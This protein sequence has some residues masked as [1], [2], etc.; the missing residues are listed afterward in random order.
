MAE[1][2]KVEG[3]SWSAGLRL[4]LVSGGP[5]LTVSCPLQVQMMGS[6]HIETSIKVTEVLLPQN[7]FPHILP[8][9]KQDNLH[10]FPHTSSPATGTPESGIWCCVGITGRKSVLAFWD[11]TAICRRVESF[12][13]SV[14]DL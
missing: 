4:A 9:P 5:C 8:Q 2:T 11:P 6:W 7:C 13:S 14:I 10:L 1:E 12:Q 3:V